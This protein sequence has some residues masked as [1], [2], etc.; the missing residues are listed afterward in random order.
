M[1]RAILLAVLVLLSLTGCDW[2]QSTFGLKGAEQQPRGRYCIDTEPVTAKRCFNNDQVAFEKWQQCV[3]RGSDPV[4]CYI[5]EPVPGPGFTPETA[6]EFDCGE[7]SYFCFRYVIV[8]LDE[9]GIDTWEGR[10]VTSSLDL[11][12]S[13]YC[14]YRDTSLTG[15][16]RIKHSRTDFEFDA[17]GLSSCGQPT[18]DYF[19]MRVSDVVGTSYSTHVRESPIPP[20]VRIDSEDYR[21]ERDNLFFRLRATQRIDIDPADQTVRVIGDFAFIARNTVPNN[22]DRYMV[23]FD[24]KFDIEGHE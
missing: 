13:G 4:K 12:D 16:L 14:E 6:P 9:D 1:T 18:D 10:I 19:N 3:A 21:P 8:D 5:Y 11:Y 15:A 20:L 17:P 23:V 2:L 22:P 24:G 7:P